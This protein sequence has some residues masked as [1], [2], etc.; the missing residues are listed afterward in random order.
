MDD[1][2]CL[3][4]LLPAVRRQELV[5]DRLRSITYIGI[6]FGTSTTVASYAVLGDGATPVSSE[7]IPIPQKL[8][9][10]FTPPC[11]SL[12]LLRSRWSA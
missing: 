9:I 2:L 6:D 10:R 5:R 7:P 8:G 11:S 1:T 4:T 3:S 12:A